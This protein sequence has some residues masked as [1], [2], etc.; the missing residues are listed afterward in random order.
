M[1]EN[2]ATIPGPEVL[3]EEE[4]GAPTADLSTAA[5]ESEG[6]DTYGYPR[7]DGAPWSD[8][9]DL[10]VAGADAQSPIPV[11]PPACGCLLVLLVS[12]ISRHAKRGLTF[13]FSKYAGRLGRRCE[14]DAWQ[15]GAR[16]W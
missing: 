6:L 1:A 15:D 13:A 3:M 8:P 10:W 5:S 14:L 11:T 16:T 12:G 4:S 2:P 7:A 9:A